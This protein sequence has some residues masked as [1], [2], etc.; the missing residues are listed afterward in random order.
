MRALKRQDSLEERLAAEDAAFRR[1]RPS[2]VKRYKGQYVA[3]YQGRVVGH[4]SDDVALV[5]RV[6]DRLG[7]VLFS[8]AR[9]EDAPTADDVLLSPASSIWKAKA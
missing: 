6:F 7:D 4:G 2:L 1:L 5:R 8:I 3:L 9:V